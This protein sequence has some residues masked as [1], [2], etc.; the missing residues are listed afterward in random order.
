LACGLTAA[1]SSDNGSNQNNGDGGVQPITSGVSTLAGSSDSG[2]IDGSRDIARFN[3]PVNVL[4]GPDGLIYV[5]DF[6]NSEVRAV[7]TDGTVST[8]VKQQGFVRPFGLTFVGKTLYVST[9]NDDTGAHSLTSGTVWRVDTSDHTATVVVRDVGRPRGLAAL[10]DG[11]IVMSDD[12]HHVVQIL[13]PATGV[14][15]PLAGAMDQ[16]GFADG[17][18]VNARFSTPWGVAVQSDGTIVLADFGNQRIRHLTVTGS[19]T[20]MAGTGNAAFADGTMQ[21]AEFNN[22]EGISIAPNGDIYVTDTGNFRV[23][24]IS[25]NAVTTFAG[26]GTGGFMDSTDPLQAEFFGLEGLDVNGDGSIVY[27]ADGNRGESLPFNR[28]RRAT[29]N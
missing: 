17:T 21:Q 9:D 10:P 2:N 13:N 18:G 29:T 26:N 16:A 24:K 15:T 5:A 14:I 3:N 6:D 7:T 1:C 20:T 8:I 12:L 19:V 23:R 27:I 25:G 11:R 4:V 22:P 28:V